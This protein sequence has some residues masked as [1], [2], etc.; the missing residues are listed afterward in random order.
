MH[1]QPTENPT[2][3]MRNAVPVNVGASTSRAVFGR[4]GASNQ[5][6]QL[7]Q[8]QNVHLAG[9]P[10]TDMAGLSTGQ[11]VTSRDESGSGEIRTLSLIKDLPSSKQ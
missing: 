11:T 1:P 10:S 8:T 3:Q 7:D 9:P 4:P 6:I 5:L 2:S